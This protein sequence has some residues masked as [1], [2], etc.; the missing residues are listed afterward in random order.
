V[1]LA[2]W[3]S[4]GHG[5]HTPR[6]E[7]PL[8]QIRSEQTGWAVG[9]SPLSLLQVPEDNPNAHSCL[10]N[11]RRR[12]DEVILLSQSHE[13]PSHHC[14]GPACQSKQPPSQHKLSQLLGCRTHMQGE[15]DHDGHT[16]PTCECCASHCEAQR[17]T[18]PHNAAHQAL[19]GSLT[20][21]K[22]PWKSQA[23]TRA[24]PNVMLSQYPH[25]ATTGVTGP[26]ST[27]LDHLCPQCLTCCYLASL[28]Y[29]PTYSAVPSSDHPP[30]C[31][32]LAVSGIKRLHMR[33]G[34]VTCAGKAK[35]A[36]AVQQAPD[37]DHVR[38][39]NQRCHASGPL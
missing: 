12:W 19:R 22:G 38:Q 8:L 28:L 15:G 16:S 11:W 5:Q 17:S 1:P 25:S 30:S 34:W 29:E 4:T 10:Q 27:H 20:V 6:N 7:L 31:G 2:W 36:W 37:L 14:V 32:G 26:A 13:C 23:H 3:G 35:Q 39:V 24:G 9:T 21:G 18:V 33:V